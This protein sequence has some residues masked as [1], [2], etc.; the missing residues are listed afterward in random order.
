MIFFDTMTMEDGV[1]QGRNID[2]NHMN[3]FADKDSGN[4]D[5]YR[6]TQSAIN[7]KLAKLECE[8]LELKEMQQGMIEEE[9]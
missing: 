1:W 7:N 8:F 2:G 3:S 4:A 6:I 9:Q 5:T